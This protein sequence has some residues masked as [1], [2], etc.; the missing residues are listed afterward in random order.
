[1]IAGF[2]Q[3]FGFWPLELITK[4]KS[5]KNWLWFHAVSVG[6][7]NAIWPLII[8]I[9]KLKPEYPIMLSCT[10]RNGYIL[11]CEKTKNTNVI[12]FYFPYDF[13][14]TISKLLNLIN[15][16]LLVI[17]E[18]EIWPNLLK[19]CKKRDIP[20]ILVNGRLS[21]KS[22][23]NYLFLK[24]YFKDIF[25]LLTKVL[26]QS[27][28]DTQKFIS[29]GVNK[30][31]IKTI[32]NIKYFSTNS[33]GSKHN[34]Q[35]LFSNNNLKLIFGSTHKGEEKI[36]LETHKSLLSENSNIQLIIAPRH[37]ERIKEIKDLIISYGYNAVLKTQ[38]QEIKS[39]KDVLL[40]DTIGELSDF[41][42]IS[43]ITIL[44]GTFAAIGGHNILEPIRAGSYTIIGPNDY[45]IKELTS[46]F[47]NENALTKVNNTNEL[48]LKVKEAVQNVSLRKDMIKNG[49]KII[50]RFENTLH[51]TTNE[52]LTFL[53]EI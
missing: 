45:K 10:T 24:F 38:S 2:T 13:P 50:K 21:D 14:F 30:N 23:R 22:F 28:T 27:D 36:A 6:E 3:K 48:I 34:L 8:E 40:I 1:M 11:A 17:A 49:Q 25:N 44:C 32:G 12:A 42:Y 31:K 46:Q 53:R 52:L 33:N 37:L 4:W 19:E 29:I 41:Y 47:L 18:T 5:M 7:I 51:E 20:T 16:K 9:T 43:D 15:L 35:N 39:I 26:S